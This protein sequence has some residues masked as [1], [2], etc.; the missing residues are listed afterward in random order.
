MA[1]QVIFQIDKVYDDINGKYLCELGI[2][3][4]MLSIGSSFFDPDYILGID[5]DSDALSICRQNLDEFEIECPIDLVQADCKQLLLKEENYEKLINKFDTCIMNPPFGTKNQKMNLNVDTKQLGIDLLFVKLA[6][7]LTTGSIYSMHKSVTRD[8][9]KTLAKSWGLKTEV[10]SELRYNIP[11]IDTRNRKLATQAK[12]K[13]IEV[14]LLR[15][16]HIV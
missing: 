7:K 5:I 6:C 16:T 12:E 2:G 13:D 3:T 15:F 1:S 8:Y 11:K 10:V 4:G 9:I 14:D